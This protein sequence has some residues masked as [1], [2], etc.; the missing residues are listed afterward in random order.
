MVLWL[1]SVLERQPGPPGFAPSRLPKTPVRPARIIGLWHCPAG[2]HRSHWVSPPGSSRQAPR[3]SERENAKA[4][5]QRQLA[6]PSAGCIPRGIPGADHTCARH[7]RHGCH[8]HPSDESSCCPG[9]L[10]GLGL[11]ISWRR[12]RWPGRGHRQSIFWSNQPH[13][14]ESAL[15]RKIADLGGSLIGIFPAR[16]G[17]KIR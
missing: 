6:V 1:S 17:L 3:R 5:P 10:L 4:S 16:H 15:S 9:S 7:R 12:W 13:S 8:L 14:A 2:R 11:R